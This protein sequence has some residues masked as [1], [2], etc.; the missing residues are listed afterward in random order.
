MEW[1]LKNNDTNKVAADMIFLDCGYFVRNALETSNV[2]FSVDRELLSA[3]D[4]L[5]IAATT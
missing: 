4:K 3:H 1:S 5:T 2:F